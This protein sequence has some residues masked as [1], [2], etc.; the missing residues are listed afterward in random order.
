LRFLTYFGFADDPRLDAGWETLFET[1]LGE[2]C[3]KCRY[4]KQPC[5]WLAVKALWAFAVAPKRGDAPAAIACA[6]EALLSY[7]FDFEEKDSR[8]LR[9]G[10]PWYNQSDLLDMLEALAVCGYAPDPRFRA[11]TQHLRQKQTDDGYWLKEGGSSAIRIGR[12]GQPNK[13]ITL[14]ALGI[15]KK[16][17]EVNDG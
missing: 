11:L 10:F 1:L 16:E 14:K 6:A 3:L 4:Q 12:K 2:N 15:L 9:F 5:L 8:W 17:A 13:W 7:D